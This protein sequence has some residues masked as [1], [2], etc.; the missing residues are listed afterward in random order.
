MMVLC[1]FSGASRSGL[2][3]FTSVTV[4]HRVIAIATEIASSVY[5]TSLLSYPSQLL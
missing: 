5:H 3:G 2:Q 1:P 4:K